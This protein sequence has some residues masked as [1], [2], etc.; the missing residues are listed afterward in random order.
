VMDIKPDSARFELRDTDQ[1][2]D[3]DAIV[4]ADTA[5][6]LLAIWGRRAPHHPLTITAEPTVWAR[7]AKVLWDATR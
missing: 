4:E 2:A 6:R 3:G 1:S 5:H 7:V